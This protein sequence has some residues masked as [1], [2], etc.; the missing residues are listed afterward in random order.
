MPPGASPTMIVR[1][2][3]GNSS[4]CTGARMRHAST[5]T[6]KPCRMML[7][8]IFSPDFLKQ[9]KDG[10]GSK[11]AATT[12]QRSVVR[13]KSVDQVAARGTALGARNPAAT[14]SFSHI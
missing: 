10:G 8:M 5:A 6:M 2:L 13:A 3:L 7:R 9:Q 14:D 12:V 1:G 4:A 11:G